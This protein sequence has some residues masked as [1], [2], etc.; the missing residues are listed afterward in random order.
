ML[1]PGLWLLQ[2]GIPGVQRRES[3]AITRYV[4]VSFRSETMKLLFK[5][6]GVQPWAALNPQ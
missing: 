3:R 4:R 1:Q 5:H 6:F 2:S